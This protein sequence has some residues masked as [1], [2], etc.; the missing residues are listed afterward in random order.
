MVELHEHVR[1]ARVED[2]V[3]MAARG[4]VY[5]N[6]E[7]RPEAFAGLR[8]YGQRVWLQCL[9]CGYEWREGLRGTRK[10]SRKCPSCHGG[11]GHYLAKG[12]NDLGSKRPD[13]ARQL[14]PE[15]NG[16]LRA[17]DLHAHAGAMV[18]W[19]GSCGHVWREKVSMRSMRIDDSCPY[20]KNRKLLRGFNDLATAHP[21][22]AAE[23]D[24]GRNGDLRPDGVVSGSARRV[25]WR[26]G[27]GHAWQISAYN[28]TG[29][30]DRGCPYCGDRKVLKGYN[31]LRTTHPKI[32]REWNKER[33][34]DL[35]PTDVI[36]NSNKRVWWKCKEGHE[37]SGLV[38]NRARKGKADPGCPYCSGRKVLAGYNDLATTH[39]GIAAMWHPRM[40]K[41][42]KP[43]GVQA[44]SRKPAWWRG[45]CGHVYQMAVRDRARA[46]PGY[47]PYCSGRKRPERPIRLD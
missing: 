31:D 12:S 10:E 24:F 3:E 29:G 8:P 47:C 44:V 9:T 14:D 19:R 35:K 21:E 30:A 5:S 46:R 23:W 28:R 26:C 41:R 18:W 1:H 36:A 22:L 25:W 34:G 45:E 38:A 17:E 40:N 32:A 4:V 43:T 6:Q 27:H 16:G 33:N 15:L 7:R 11:R 42:L 20:C 37:W 13:V 2:A 39:P